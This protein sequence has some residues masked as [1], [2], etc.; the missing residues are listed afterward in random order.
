M[1]G[2]DKAFYEKKLASV[3]FY[4]AQLLPRH[5]GYQDAVMGGAEIGVSLNEACF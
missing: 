3:N 5:K 2:S 4:F 1:G